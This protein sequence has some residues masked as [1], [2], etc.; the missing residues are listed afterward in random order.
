M[1]LAVSGCATTR[2]SIFLGAGLGVGA[3]GAVGYSASG[4]HPLGPTLIGVASGAALGA[5]LGYVIHGSNRKTEPPVTQDTINK[6]NLPFLTKPE[7]KSMWV[8]D[9]IEEDGRRYTEGHRVY[10]IDKQS[11]FSQ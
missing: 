3:G 1:A 7:V 10:F 4:K 6:S 8:P 2:D 11:T 5:L 9:K